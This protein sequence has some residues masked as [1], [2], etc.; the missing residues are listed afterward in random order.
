MNMFIRSLSNNYLRVPGMCHAL[1]SG[2]RRFNI[3][4]S[5][6]VIQAENASRVEHGQYRD[7]NMRSNCRYELLNSDFSRL[8]R[9]YYRSQGINVDVKPEVNVDNWLKTNTSTFNP[10]IAEAIFHYAPRVEGSER[11]ELC[12]ST[13]EMQSA[14]I[15]FVHKQQLILDGTFGLSA[16]RLL[17]WIAM[18]VNEGNHGVPLHC[19]CSQHLLGQRQ[20]MLDMTR[21]S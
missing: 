1:L 19:S 11:F 20:R 9:R 12:I 4:T 14:A 7:I 10:T 16:S 2:L 5:I 3:F 13:P 18:G 8:Y 17:I 21:R 15:K 6:S